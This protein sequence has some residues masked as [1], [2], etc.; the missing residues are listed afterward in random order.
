MRQMIIRVLVENTSNIPELGSEHG[1]C[2]YIETQRHKLLFDT[3]AS[4]LFV[5]NATKLD[6]GLSAVDAVVI[7]HGHYDHGGG[8]K[9]FLG[10]NE[11][12]RIYLNRAAF[13]EHY[14]QRANGETRYIG[15]EPSLLASERLVF[16]GK[17]LV[18]DEELELF[19]GVECGGYFAP[20]A[21]QGLL[22]R[23]GG[24]LLP[25][26]FAHEQN[27]ILREYG[28]AVL[29]SGCAH[30]GIVNI[31]QRFQEL[32]GRL[33]D[34]VIGGFHLVRGSAGLN[35]PPALIHALGHRLAGTRAM[36]Y[37]CHCT[38]VQPYLLLKEEMGESIQSLSTGDQ[39]TI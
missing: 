31:L 25:D 15:L 39:I 33:P 11:K 28:N 22:M 17:H 32:A 6:V 36:F 37:T 24:T 19:A 2:L 14:S 9:A 1:L 20:A 5:Q 3:G 23:H 10:V 26:P 34:C 4:E 27:L 21:N 18:I 13:G 7:S 29:L 8:L 16:A 12:A 35:E 38:G 30:A